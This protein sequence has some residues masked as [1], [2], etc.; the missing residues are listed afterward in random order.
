MFLLIIKNSSK[1]NKEKVHL[2]QEYKYRVWSD[3]KNKDSPF[4]IYITNPKDM[5]KILGLF[6]NPYS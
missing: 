4:Y 6:T 3:P 5:T 1:G 2:P